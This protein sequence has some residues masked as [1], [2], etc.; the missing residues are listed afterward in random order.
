MKLNPNKYIF[1]ASHGKLLGF[2]ISER[3]I[4]VD[5]SKDK[6]II[7]MPTPYIEK[8][9]HSFLGHIQYINHFIAQ[10]TPICEPLLKLLRKN[11]LTQWSNNYQAASDKIKKNLLSLPMSVFPKP[12]RL[13]ILYLTVHDSS[14]GCVLGQHDK[15]ENKE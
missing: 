13:L 6:A 14:I 15:I 5:P 11:I 2:I 12:D 10:L 8:A 1:K 7:R 9:V 3:G 4:E